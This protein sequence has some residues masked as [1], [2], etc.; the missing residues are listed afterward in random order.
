MLLSIDPHA[1]SPPYEQIRIQIAALVRSGELPAG[2][3]L[4]TVRRLAGD[5]G[6]APNTVARSYRVLESDG[7]IETRGRKGSFVSRQGNANERLAQ[8]AAAT[9]ACRTRQ[10]GILPEDGIRYIQAALETDTES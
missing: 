3:R 9:Y 1:A 4:P 6:L 10:L 2:T 8:A 7:I 5:L